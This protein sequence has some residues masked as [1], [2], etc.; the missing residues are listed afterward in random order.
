MCVIC[1][2]MLSLVILIALLAAASHAQTGAKRPAVA[3]VKSSDNILFV[4]SRGPSEA[5][6]D[7]IVMLRRSRFI[8]LPEAGLDQFSKLE[9]KYYREGKKYRLLFGGGEAGD[10]VVKK[11]PARAPDCLGAQASVGLGVEIETQ[12][13]I[14]GIVMGLATDSKRLGRRTASRRFPTMGERSSISELAKQFYKKKGISAQLVQSMKPVNITAMDLDGDDRAEIVATFSVKSKARIEARHFLFVI[15]EP[16]ASDYKLGVARYE[17][18]TKKSLPAGGSFDE[19]DEYALTE[20]L[21]DQVDLDGDNV[22]EVITGRKGWEGITY[23][24][25]KKQKA[26]WKKIYEVY[27]YR[28]AY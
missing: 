16:A 5:L 20:V 9:S 2:R 8:N 27:N 1:H 14:G 18:M 19:V 28:C 12:S 13:K 23:R 11:Q 21:V 15:A 26:Q 6:I 25:Y 4:V 17:L 7:P 24:I 10:V 22:A 3:E